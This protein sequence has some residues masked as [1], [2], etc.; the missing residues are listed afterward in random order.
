[1]AINKS[2][3]QTFSK[4]DISSQVRVLSHGQLYVAFSRAR[5]RRGI[6]VDASQQ[7]MQNMKHRL[8]G[9]AAIVLPSPPGMFFGAFTPLANAI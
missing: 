1:M 5:S 9:S 2:R 3:G 7:L 6:A 4:V 8:R